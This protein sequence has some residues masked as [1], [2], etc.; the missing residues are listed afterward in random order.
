MKLNT[1][2]LES[3]TANYST[4]A[5]SIKGQALADAMAWY[6]EAQA[7]AKHLTTLTPWTLEVASSVVSS[8]SPRN[9][10][11]NN[12]AHALSFAMGVNP[13]GLKNNLRMAQASTRLGFG[14]LKGAKTN[15]F[16]RAI[17]G[18][19]SAVV[20]DTWM[21]K[22]AGLDSTKSVNKTQYA[23]LAAAV[24][25]VA[26]AMKWDNAQAQAAIWCAVRGGHA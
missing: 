10:W 1:Q 9:K 19:M 3:V 13:K 8:F 18:D 25:R 16:A 11:A 5:D 2:L 23:T 12:K 26:H 6:C 21:I 24:C 17:S 4:L 15:A 7:F 22:A 14:A 20:I